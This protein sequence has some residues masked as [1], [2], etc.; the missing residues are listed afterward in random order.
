MR[1]ERGYNVARAAVI[2]AYRELERPTTL[3]FI[4]TESPEGG[5]WYHQATLDETEANAVVAELMSTYDKDADDFGPYY[6]S[7]MELGVD[8]DRMRAASEDYR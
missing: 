6:V 7:S 3:Y 4:C 2:A 8:A 5:H 1:C